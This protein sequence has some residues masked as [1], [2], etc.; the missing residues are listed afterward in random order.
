MTPFSHAA[1]GLL[2]WKY[3][4][5]RRDARSLLAF[6]FIACAVDVDFLLYYSLGRPE[7]FRH[8]VFSHNLFVIAALS[9][10]F[11]AYLKTPR[12]RWGLLLAGGS[13]L[14]MDMFVIDTLAPVGI[15]P[16]FPVWN[17]FFNVSFFPYVAKETWLSVLSWHNLYVLGLEALIFIVPAVILAR[18]ELAALA[19]KKVHGS[20]SS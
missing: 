8:Q 4:A 9:L 6:V 7:V 3:S 11:F 2:G 20:T 12:E 13:H 15:R 17:Q 16:F 10:P 18:G 19:G 5:S 1:M 14:L